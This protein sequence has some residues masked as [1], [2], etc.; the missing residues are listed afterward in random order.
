MTKRFYDLQPDDRIFIRPLFILWN[1]DRPG[2]FRS[3]ERVTKR[4]VIDE[5]GWKWR[6]K[7]GRKVDG[8]LVAEVATLDHERE[9][10]LWEWKHRASMRLQ[11]AKEA[12]EKSK[13]L[14]E[15]TKAVE[16]IKL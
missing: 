16:G 13:T 12:V 2:E 6:R 5:I 14:D 7:T 9:L 1:Y 8:A 4:Y 15:V 11:E 10:L 3:V